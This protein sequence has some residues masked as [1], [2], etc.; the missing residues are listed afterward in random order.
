MIRAEKLAALR[1]IVE[2]VSPGRSEEV[3]GPS[4]PE[5]AAT[6]VVALALREAS[7]KV[8]T[9]PPVDALQDYA[10]PVW[11]GELPLGLAVGEPVRDPRCRAAVPVPSYVHSYSRA[12]A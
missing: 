4:E 10:L 12:G 3:R 6:E 2:H 11:A 5:L 1:A 9:G 8:R 7:A